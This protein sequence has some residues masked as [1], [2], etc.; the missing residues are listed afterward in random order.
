MSAIYIVL[1]G[2]MIIFLPILM[3]VMIY[4]SKKMLTGRPAPTPPAATGAPVAPAAAPAPATSSSKKLWW[5]GG[6]VLLLLILVLMWTFPPNTWVNWAATT[7][8]QAIEKSLGTG[9]ANWVMWIILAVVIIGL[10]NFFTGDRK[11]SKVIP[12]LNGGVILVMTVLLFTGIGKHFTTQDPTKAKEHEVIRLDF[13]QAS[14]GDVKPF[15]LMNGGMLIITKRQAQPGQTPFQI[16]LKVNGPVGH[17]ARYVP[18]ANSDTVAHMRLSSE[19]KQLLDDIPSNFH[20]GVASL[21]QTD[22]D[23]CVIK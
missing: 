13:S 3:G 18:V 1:I 9:W 12:V 17:K 15:V 11:G 14:D 5:I 2:A 7:P 8:G 21:H 10:I 6:S 19:G 23:P 20:N 16:C 22:G 4:M